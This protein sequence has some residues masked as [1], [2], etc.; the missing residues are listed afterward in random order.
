MQQPDFTKDTFG[1]KISLEYA[2]A[3]IE[4]GINLNNMITKTIIQSEVNNPLASKAAVMNNETYNAFIFTK[5]LIMRFFDGS[6]KDESGN[7]R[8]SNFLM[9]LLGAHPYDT[10]DFKAGSPTVMTVGCERKIINPGGVDGNEEVRF[11]P[12]GIA[13]PANEYPPKMVVTQLDGG[14]EKAQRI[15]YFLMT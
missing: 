1:G 15:S 7:P 10:G 4:E 9:V 8:S 6:E 14:E 5:D 3:M 2:N 13:Y 11:Y 12:L